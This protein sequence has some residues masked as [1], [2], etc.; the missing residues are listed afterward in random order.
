MFSLTARAYVRPIPFAELV[1]HSDFI[2]IGKVQ[3]VTRVETV[4][5]AKIEVSRILKGSPVSELYF[6]AQ[7]TWMCDISGAEV[8]ETALF[9]LSKYQFD[10]DPKPRPTPD[11]NG[12]VQLSTDF[13]EPLGFREKLETMTNGA[14]FL[15]VEHAGRG[16]MLLREVEDVEYI[17]VWSKDV[18]LPH[19]IK[20]IAGPEPKYDFIRSA[21]LDQ[22]LSYIEE[23][24]KGQAAKL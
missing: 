6:L 18:I 15:Q 12:F 17:T 5:V 14:P 22:V 4:K 11:A 3:S 13:E 21:L 19:D 2:V 1:K 20:T 23:T 16:K 8:D 7:D 24:L 10:P 9:F